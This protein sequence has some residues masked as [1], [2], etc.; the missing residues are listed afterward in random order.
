MSNAMTTTVD[1]HGPVA[2]LTLGEGENR[3]SPH[4]LDAVNSHLKDIEQ[5][6]QALV[7]VGHPVGFR[8]DA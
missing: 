3:F 5:H 8:F 1:H 6:S 2:V 4:W 7:T